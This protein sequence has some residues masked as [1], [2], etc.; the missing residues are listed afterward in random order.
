MCPKPSV[1]SSSFVVMPFCHSGVPL[2]GTSALSSPSSLTLPTL[3][4]RWRC[5]PLYSLTCLLIFFRPPFHLYLGHNLVSCVHPNPPQ[6][7]AHN[8]APLRLLAGCPSLAGV[9]SFHLLEPDSDRPLPFVFLNYGNPCCRELEVLLG[10]HLPILCICLPQGC[11]SLSAT[12]TN[13]SC[14]Q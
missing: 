14:F 11:H 1:W 13:T 9:L 10:V 3:V 12:C 7:A 8:H 5:F 6:I 4:V 2:F